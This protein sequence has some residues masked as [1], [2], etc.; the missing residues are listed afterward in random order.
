MAPCKEEQIVTVK[1][2]N[3]KRTEK[4]VLFFG[5]AVSHR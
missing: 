5:T 2:S 3:S 4:S 1:E